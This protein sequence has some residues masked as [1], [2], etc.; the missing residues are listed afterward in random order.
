MSQNKELPSITPEQRI[1]ILKR[2][3]QL[4]STHKEIAIICGVSRKTIER[5]IRA[6]ELTGGWDD[7]IRREFTGLFDGISETD[8]PLA[9][10]EMSKLAARTMTQRTESKV[11]GFGTLLIWRPGEEPE[12]DGED[13]DQ[14]T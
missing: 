11:E 12:P 5:D 13:E 7:W 4:G 14:N 8:E 1:E 10:R 9:F 2:E 3:L 6:W